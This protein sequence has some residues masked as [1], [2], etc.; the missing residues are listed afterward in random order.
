[1][2]PD[3]LKDCKSKGEEYLFGILKRLPENYIVYWEAQF[4]KGA[5]EDFKI[6]I[7]VDFI[8]SKSFFVFAQ[9]YQFV[10]E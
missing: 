9:N 10:F 7:S 4:Q 3:S 6:F 2:I 5:C 1:M 8:L